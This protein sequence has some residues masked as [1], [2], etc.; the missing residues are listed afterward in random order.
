MKRVLAY[1]GMGS[2]LQQPLD[3]LYRALAELNGIPRTSLQASS[4]FY[5]SSPMGPA[6]QPDDINAV[7]ALH[8]ELAALDLLDQLQRIELSHGRQ[9][10]LRWG[11]RTLDLDLLL[12]GDQVIQNERL[13]VPH[14]GIARRAFVLLPLAELAPELEVPGLGTV[15]DMLAGLEIEDVA[16]II[17]SSR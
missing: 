1:I 17:P 3:Q 9:R 4:S 2:N 7:A 15:S 6:D 16:R 14:P 11:P 10:G 13:S 8:T 12:Y 5:T